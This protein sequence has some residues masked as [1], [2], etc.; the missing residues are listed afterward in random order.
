MLSRWRTLLPLEAPR[1]RAAGAAGEVVLGGEA[2]DV[3]DVTDDLG[4][5]HGAQ[6]RQGRERSAGRGQSVTH[7]GLVVLD[8]PVEAAQVGQQVAGD[9][10][11]AGVR[12]GRGPDALHGDSGL[13]GGQPGGN[14]AGQQVAQHGVAI[15]NW[16]P[17]RREKP[18][19][20]SLKATSGRAF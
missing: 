18:G 1:G 8:L 15:P 19:G 17:S 12:G 16:Q 14:P 11:A 2:S 13:V 3:A 4:G 9:V 20:Q 7:F 6:T 5:E 10:P